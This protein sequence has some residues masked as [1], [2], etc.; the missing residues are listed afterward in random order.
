MEPEPKTPTVGAVHRAMLEAKGDHATAAAAL[1]VSVEILNS[2]IKASR[3]LTLYWNGVGVPDEVD[4][5]DRRPEP[6]E[7]REQI[8]QLNAKDVQ[9][10]SAVFSQVNRLDSTDWEGMG[11]QDTKTLG[12]MRQF[13][14]TGAGRS[15]LKLMDTMQG[16][17]AYCFARTSR[18]FSDVAD[19]LELELRK[20]KPDDAKV[21]LL[22]TRFKDLADMMRQFSKEVSNAANIR[23][24]IADRARRIQKAGDKM[25]KPGWKGPNMQGQKGAA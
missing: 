5:L 18:Q 1:G 11:V 6:V 25:R 13:E 17:M 10:S 24:M 4:S 20:D 16:G 9:R 15:V 19:G 21:L 2:A 3:D 7:R 12:M 14:G 8:I 22:H 23:L